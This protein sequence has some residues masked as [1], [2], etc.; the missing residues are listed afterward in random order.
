AT[1]EDIL[2]NCRVV[3]AETRLPV[4]ADL[5]N[6]FAD[7]PRRA[8]EAIR[9]AFEHGAVGGSIEDFTGRTEAPI[10]DLGHAV[11]KV[12][13][14]AEAARSLP[15]P[16]VLT[17]RAENF[18]HGRRALDDTIRRLQAYAA[19]GADVLYA[20]GLSTLD[21]MRTVVAAVAPKPV[22]VVMGFADPTLTLA[23]LG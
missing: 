21:E 18:L 14:A 6:G 7:E 15:V 17:G 22:N 4:N 1:L 13:A 5:E 23:Q 16:F 2:E 10:Y 19:A 9:R 8:A 3:S 12:H 20:P 11:E